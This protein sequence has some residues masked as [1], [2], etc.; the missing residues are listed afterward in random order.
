M[1]GG[2]LQFGG[3]L[4]CF[5]RPAAKQPF[6]FEPVFYRRHALTAALFPQFVGNGSNVVQCVSLVVR[7]SHCEYHFL[8]VLTIKTCAARKGKCKEVL[9]KKRKQPAR[10]GASPAMRVHLTGRMTEGG[11]SL[12]R[13]GGT[14]MS[15]A[16]AGT[17]GAMG[18]GIV[19]R[20]LIRCQKGAE[21]CFGFGVDAGELA[22]QRSH[23]CRKLIDA[24]RVV[25]L[26]SGS[27][28]VAVCL[29]ARVNVLT[30]GNSVC[31]K[32]AGLSLLCSV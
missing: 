27:K 23:G 14:S 10:V 3:L 4:R 20:L 24:C 19:G 31:E 7:F 16:A 26:D 25:C 32:R 13:W 5:F 2:L 12:L 18:H 21:G 8:S 17:T 30:R 1:L 29:Q 15:W 28:R 22:L 11:Q 6:R 9:V